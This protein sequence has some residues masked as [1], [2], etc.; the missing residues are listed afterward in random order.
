MDTLQFFQT[1]LPPTGSYYLATIS[2][3][4][5]GSKKPSQTIHYAY[6]SL[7]DLAAGVEKHSANTSVNLFHAC[8]SYLA[9][10]VMVS[11]SK[12][13]RKQENW[14]QAK[15]LWIDLDCGLEKCNSG[16][17]YIDQDTARAGILEFCT[18]A[19]FPTP[20][21]VN[22]GN[23]VHCYW[24]FTSPIPAAQ[25]L[26]LARVFKL[27]LAH[28]KVL[29]DDSCTADFARILRPVGS[30]N[31]KSDVPKPVTCELEAELIRPSLIL[32]RLK[33]L[34]LEAELKPEVCRS[35]SPNFNSDHIVP[36]VQIPTSAEEVAKHCNQ[37]K[38]VAE[39]QGDVSRPVWFAAIGLTT[40]CEEGIQ[41][42]EKWTEKRGE[43]G[44]TDTD[45]QT[46]YNSWDAKPPS[47]A[48][49]EADNPKG[50]QGCLH[51]GKINTPLVL[52]RATKAMQ[53]TTEVEQSLEAVDRPPL[54]LPDKNGNG[55]PFGT[56]ANVKAVLEYEGV[57]A[58]YNQMTKELEIIVPGV[59]SVPD[60]SSN[61]NQTAALDLL[62]RH[63]VPYARAPEQINAIAASNPYCPVRQMIES[64]SW[65]GI[66]RFEL[67]AAQITTP[68]PYETRDYL[69]KWLIQA[70]AAVYLIEGL[71]AAGM[72]VLAG[73]QG[74]GKTMLIRILASVV[75][76]SFLEGA[77]LDPSNKDSVMTIASHW[78]VE[79][80]ELDA[81]F[82]KSDLAQ[83]KAFI[84]KRLDKFRRPYSKKDSEFP[85]RTVMAGTVN[86]AEFLFD[87]TGNRR[88]WV[89]Q[90]D[91]IQ[92]DHS[93][94]IQQLWAEAKTWY[95][96]GETWHFNKQEQLSLN[97]HNS[98]FEVVDPV[99]E[100]IMSKFNFQSMAK[101]TW[102]TATRIAELALFDRPTKGEVQRVST[103]VRGLN[104]NQAKCCGGRRLLL[105]PGVH[106]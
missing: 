31:N 30:F 5:K 99:A 52:G 77:T 7:E 18:A 91:S 85:R 103:V 54:F 51:R 56:T 80:G 53:T 101:T 104:G 28:H 74:I 24:P 55:R 89:I 17:G 82:R 75:A 12:S 93:I 8:G 27:V 63:G 62:T 102:L 19:N 86:E 1:M 49:F 42:A 78:I 76:D 15:A 106:L 26:A 83:L 25:W 71:S 96:A 9:E 35:Y 10:S 90:A 84:T 100:K 32:E 2:K 64:R 79:L 94:D 3:P 46:R 81:T 43:T 95:D 59:S 61:S 88:F 60:E 34:A 105:V 72:L 11:G 87:T 20:M 45:Y 65:D 37:I 41:I 70:V 6:S 98:Q 23:G 39:T 21:I 22:S 73:P 47:C 57:T 14:A 67:F 38:N 13:Y 40:F 33:A 69:R 16:V 4:K 50:C 36:A 58:R 68:H 66:P 44:H 29:A 97:Q 92:I 48:K